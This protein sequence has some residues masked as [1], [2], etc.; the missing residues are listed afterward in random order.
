MS[1]RWG[2]DVRSKI[3]VT[4]PS[5]HR[6][7]TPNA[8]NFTHPF[9]RAIQFSVFR[10]FYRSSRDSEI[11]PTG[12]CRDSEI[13]PTKELNDPNSQLS[14]LTFSKLR[15]IIGLYYYIFCNFARKKK[16]IALTLLCFK[17]T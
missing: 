15:V 14:V 1:P 2:L 6:K 13:A 8:K 17:N 16:G 7:E 12:I 3:G 4:N 5:Y 9:P 11:A 10:Q